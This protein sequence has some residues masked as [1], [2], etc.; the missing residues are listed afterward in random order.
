[1]LNESS[2]PIFLIV[3]SSVDG[4]T[5]AAACLVLEANRRNEPAPRVTRE[6]GHRDRRDHRHLAHGPG[7]RLVSA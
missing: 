6:I 1:M 4:L 2:A 3:P 7:P 5:W